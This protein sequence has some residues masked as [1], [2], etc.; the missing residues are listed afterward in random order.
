MEQA[1]SGRGQSKARRPGAEQRR[2][3]ESRDTLNLVHKLTNKLAAPFSTY[4]ERQHDIS[5]N[6]FRLLMIIGQNPNA[7]SHELVALTGV[8]PMSVSRAVSTLAK[9]GRISVSRDAKNGRRK[10]LTLTPEG[11]RLY[12]A[13]QGPTD[14][15]ARYLLSDLDM[16]EILTFNQMLKRLIGTLEATDSGGQSLF[17]AATKPGDSEA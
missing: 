2:V 17:L 8:S 12:E 15:V 16:D 6:E 10:V 9:D 13:M 14:L 4:L 1:V 5:F 3:D 7:A 11:R